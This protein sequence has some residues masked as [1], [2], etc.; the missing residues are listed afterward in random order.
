[1]QA[2]SRMNE[3]ILS[4]ISVCALTF[5]CAKLPQTNISRGYNDTK[6]DRIKKSNIHRPFWFA[7][8]QCDV[9]RPRRGRW[10]WSH[11]ASPAWL[12]GWASW[13]CC[14]SSCGSSSQKPPW[15]ARHPPLAAV[16]PLG[17]SP[18]KTQGTRVRYSH[19]TSEI[20]LQ[21]QQKPARLRFQ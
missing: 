8:S 7:F 15:W 14:F 18:A 13:P 19:D 4:K 3:T 10:C 21:H 16:W 6:T 1:M 9:G 20:K 2:W 17:G 11:P 12:W 5:K